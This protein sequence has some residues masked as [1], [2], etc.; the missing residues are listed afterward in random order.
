MVEMELVALDPPKEI[1]L[2]V[3]V[4]LFGYFDDDVVV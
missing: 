2:G 3:V 4:I 1:D